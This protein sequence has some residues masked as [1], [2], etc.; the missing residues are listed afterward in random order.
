MMHA[1]A[2]ASLARG[3]A[4]TETSEE[5]NESSAI[6]DDD[7]DGPPALERAPPNAGAVAALQRQP[8]FHEHQGN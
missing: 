1:E 4:L 5:E 6:S 3:E 8:Q 2:A 7:D